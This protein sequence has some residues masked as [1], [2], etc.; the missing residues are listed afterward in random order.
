MSLVRSTPVSNTESHRAVHGFTIIEVLII[1]PIALLVIAGLVSA[2]VAMIGDALVTNARSV[3]IYNT[4]DALGRIEQDAR[5]SINFMNTLTNLK[6]PQG[7]DNGTSSFQSTSGDL[8]LTQQATT[9]SPY[10]Q[11]R[12]LVYYKNQPNDCGTNENANRVLLSR[13]VYFLRNG[14]LWRRVVVNDANRDAT[15]DGNTV[16]DTPYQR[17][18][19]APLDSPAPTLN[20]TVGSTCQTY[21]ERLVD[22]VSSFSTTYYTATGA[23]TTD[24]TQALSIK[25]D[26]S[27]SQTVAGQTITQSGSI[28]VVRSNDVPAPSDPSAPTISIQNP[29]LPDYNNPIK[30][31]VEWSSAFATYYTYQIKVG[32]GSWSSAVTT[33]NPTATIS[34]PSALT[35]YSILVT[36]YNDYGKTAQTQ[37]DAQTALWTPCTLQ[38]GWENYPNYDEAKFTMTSAKIIEIRGLV[39]SGSA[40]AVIC[41]LPSGLRPSST[42]AF[43]MLTDGAGNGASARVNIDSDGNVRATAYTNWLSLSGID[44]TPASDGYTWTNFSLQNGWSNN[45]DTSLARLSYTTD[46]VGRT[47]IRGLANAGTTSDNTV[48]AQTLPSGLRPNEIYHLPAVGSGTA[49][50]VGLNGSAGTLVAKGDASTYSAV[51]QMFYPSSATGWTNLTF[52]NNW[53]VYPGYTSPQYRKGSDGIVTVKGF[54]RKTSGT[55][56]LWDVIGCLGTGFRPANQITFNL[57]T[58]SST[59]PQN[60]TGRIDI[61]PDGCIYYLNA[62]STWTSLD[63]IKFFADGS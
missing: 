33:A 3:V 19:C 22:N 61:K 2:M 23:T 36:A 24:P 12:K 8:I 42:L 48:M 53:V 58:Y 26:L 55:S 28:R 21:D 1:A 43:P 13:S 17:N 41:T 20:G 52:Q 4:Q 62:S 10:E 18:S 56:A 31:T 63:N 49:N 5:I 37:Y 40:N 30:A 57:D 60:G 38:N 54:I 14:S 25:V 11:T 35:T 6:S 45:P 51:Q 47:H 32:A 50:A 39:R 9:S 27:I 16:C 44:F 7:K 29:N 34:T 59:A 46:S 15:P